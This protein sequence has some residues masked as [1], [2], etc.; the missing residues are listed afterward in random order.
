MNNDLNS[1]KDILKGIRN[2]KY[3][4]MPDEVIEKIIDSVTM[5][6]DDRAAAT[7]AIRAAVG[8]FI[9]SLEIPE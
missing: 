7:D 2:E 6:P 4:E 1:L 8:E 3:P 5:H 9:N